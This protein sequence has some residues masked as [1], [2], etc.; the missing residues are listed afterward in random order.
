MSERIVERAAERAAE[1]AGER[2]AERAGERLAERAA[3]RAGERLAERAAE[4]AGE[5]LAERAAERAGERLA[6]RAAERAGE[7]LAERAGERLAERAAERAGERLAERAAERAGERLAERA[8][9]RVAGRAGAELLERTTMTTAARAAG[10]GIAGFL[11]RVLVGTLQG[12]SKASGV[13]AG[14]VLG[15]E[16]SG[17]FRA[18]ERE[19]ESMARAAASLGE[20][21][22]SRIMPRIGRGL[23]VALPI[24][25]TL[26]VLKL[27]KDDFHRWRD[28]RALRHRVAVRDARPATNPR[29]QLQANAC[30]PH[31]PAL[32]G[33][34]LPGGPADGRDGRPSPFDQHHS[35]P[36]FAVR[37]RCAHRGAPAAHGGDLGHRGGPRLDHVCHR[38]GDPCVQGTPSKGSSQSSQVTPARRSL[39]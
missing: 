10:G 18:I 28:M 12:I 20:R 3:E 15:S 13:I 17:A 37:H 4:R 22:S 27:C 14:R 24:L 11:E 33:C 29:E 16:A 23:L 39:F 34:H 36:P 6:E 21:L 5:R 9:E 38:G 7:R 35:G 31:S 1:R 30:L 2:L 25:G 26:F 32:P 19:A 8:G